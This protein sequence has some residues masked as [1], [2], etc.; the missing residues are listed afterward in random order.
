MWQ[1]FHSY[2]NYFHCSVCYFIRQSHFCSYFDS[3]S[4]NFLSKSFWFS[5]LA[6]ILSRWAAR[7]QLHAFTAWKVSKNGVMSGP[8]FPAFGLHTERCFVSPRIQSECGK[9]RTRNNSLFGQFSC[10]AFF[11]NKT[12]ISNIRPKIAKKN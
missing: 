12:F 1:H 5:T 6:K 8:Y 7:E 10:S 3:W 2:R 11:I 9:I 4:N